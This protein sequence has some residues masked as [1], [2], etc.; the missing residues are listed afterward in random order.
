MSEGRLYIRYLGIISIGARER[1]IE[2][3]H[4]PCTK[5]RMTQRVLILDL[6]ILATNSC[7][8]A[9]I[10]Y[11]FEKHNAVL[12]TYANAPL[13]RY[14]NIHETL[15]YSTPNIYLTEALSSLFPSLNTHAQL[16]CVVLI[17][18]LCHRDHRDA[19]HTV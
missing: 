17:I 14:A 18:T 12:M 10:H 5:A 19:L 7:R 1:Y 13:Q 11:E 15:L 3:H 8:H 4:M 16:F 6:I 9:H 2:S